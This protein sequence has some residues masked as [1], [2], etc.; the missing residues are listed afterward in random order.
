MNGDVPTSVV[1]GN[2]IHES[3]SRAVAMQGVELLTVEDNVAYRVR[4][5]NFFL[6]DAIEQN[7]VIRYN[8]AVSALRSPNML[9][10]DLTVAAFMITNPT[11]DLIGNVAAGSDFYGFCYDL[12][13]A[14]QGGGALSDVCPQGNPVGEVSDN[15]AHSSKY[16][17]MRIN[18]LYARTFPCDPI[19][20]DSLADDPW[21]DNP[22]IT[23]IFSNFL[24]YKNRDT[25]LL[26]EYVGNVVVDGFV[27]VEN[28]KI[29]VEFIEANFTKENNELN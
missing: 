13:V 28:G 24:L 10:S 16:Y 1:R 15:V 29:G 21:A 22:S 20:K 9:Q 27:F 7:N 17:G 4:G 6:Q 5:H 2:S 18:R 3:Y 19:R 11:N 12:P 8:L 26:A 14:P 25:G 23:S